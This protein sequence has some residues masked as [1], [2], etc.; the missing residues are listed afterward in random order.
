MTKRKTDDR[1]PNL[2]EA[3][4]GTTFV[5][6]LNNCVI[7]EEIRVQIRIFLP[8]ILQLCHAV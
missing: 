6:E 2:L 3:V 5:L 7:A 1:P 4:D 8:W